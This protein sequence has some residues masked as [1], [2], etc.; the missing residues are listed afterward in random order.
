MK[1]KNQLKGVEEG[2]GW[3]RG[4]AVFLTKPCRTLGMFKLCARKILFKKKKKKH[5]KEQK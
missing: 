5:D 2:T 1:V 4:S 3:S